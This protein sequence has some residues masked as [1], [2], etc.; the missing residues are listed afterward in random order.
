MNAVIDASAVVAALVDSG[1]DGEWAESAVAA[2]ALAAPELVLAE[3]TNILRRL[4]RAEIISR[5]EASG[6]QADLLGMDIELFPFAPFARRVW[7]LRSNLTSYDAWYV[8]LA[9]VLDCPLPTLDR[10]LARA[11][12]PGCAFILPAQAVTSAGHPR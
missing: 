1:R 8:A 4:E 2:N 11:P 6:A 5:I 10:K 7:E 12:G 9:E 3:S